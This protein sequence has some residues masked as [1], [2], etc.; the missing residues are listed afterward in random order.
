MNKSRERTVRRNNYFITNLGLI[1]QQFNEGRIDLI[2]SHLIS[3]RIQIK[4]VTGF[5]KRFK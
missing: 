4:T 5:E 2:F 3:S 1:K